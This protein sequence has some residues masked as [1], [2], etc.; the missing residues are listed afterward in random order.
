MNIGIRFFVLFVIE[1]I[2]QKKKILNWMVKN[3][4]RTV[5]DVGKVMRDYYLNPDALLKRIK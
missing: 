5:T 4:T 3:N 2:D 1:I